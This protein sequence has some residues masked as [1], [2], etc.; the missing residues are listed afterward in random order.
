[1]AFH[2]AIWGP[3]S[4]CLVIPPSFKA[5]ESPPHSSE[6]GKSECKIIEVFNGPGLEVA[7]IIYARYPLAKFGHMV[8]P[9]CMGGWE[10]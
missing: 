9:N 2:M 3:R 8:T 10:M 4:F 6:G 7:H 5:F 1:M